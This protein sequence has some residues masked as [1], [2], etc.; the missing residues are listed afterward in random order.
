MAWTKERKRLE[1]YRR[2]L[3]TDLTRQY[4]EWMMDGFPMTWRNLNYPRRYEIRYANEA[5]RQLIVD[6]A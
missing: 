6:T 1:R 5:W 3:S 2:K 4:V